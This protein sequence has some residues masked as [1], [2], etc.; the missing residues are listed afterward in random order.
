VRCWGRTK[1]LSRCKNN[2]KFFVCYHHK[3][4]PIA[5]LF[6]I[7]TVIGL[8]AGIFQD[9]IKPLLVQ[10]NSIRE[11]LEE[12]VGLP[13][14]ELI[15]YDNQL[16]KL[17]KERGVSAQQLKDEIDEW[18]ENVKTNYDKGLAALYQE[19][20]Q[21]AE[22]Y[23]DK[24]IESSE[25]ELV[26]GYFYRGNAQF[27]SEKYG[28]AIESYKKAIA[29]N[30]DYADAHYNLGI[31]YRKQG[32]Y[33]LAIASYQKAIAINPDD[34]KAHYNLGYA[35]RKQGKYDLEIK[36]YK[37]AI[38]IDPD[39]AKAHYNLGNAYGEQGEYDLAIASYQK[40]IAI[41]PNLAEAH[42]SLG[43]AYRKQGEYEKAIDAFKTAIGINPNF[44]SPE[45]L[46]LINLMQQKRKDV[47]LR[48]K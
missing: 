43:I 4:Q 9:L 33:D 13:V 35:Y 30:P 45:L 7:L 38:A 31:A 1:I 39:L 34:A 36:S 46:E 48:Q 40:A 17:A 32:E 25:Q 2:T 47:R 24:F 14:S 12:I 5:L 44:E 26:L 8:F 22:D 20:Y 23:L 19:K 41:D 21:E 18:I 28:Q 27:D 29:I 11:V 15:S 3:F 37:K 42:Y 6:T 16:Q 10:E